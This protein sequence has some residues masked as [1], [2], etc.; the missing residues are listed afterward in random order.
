[1]NRATFSLIRDFRRNRS[2]LILFLAA[3]LFLAVVSPRLAAAEE[4]LSY[5]KENTGADCPKPAL[6]EFS[7]LRPIPHLPDPFTKGDGSR[8]TTREEWRCRRAE[9]KSLIERYGVGVKPGK[10]GVFKAS[11]Q[12]ETITI[13]V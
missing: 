7:S 11:L 4:P 6:P 3:L 1:M 13:I 12:G 10:P 9:I 5:M 2:A 8:V